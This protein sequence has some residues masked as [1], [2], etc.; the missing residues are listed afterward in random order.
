MQHPTLVISNLS[1]L[2]TTIVN[3]TCKPMST[4][5]LFKGNSCWAHFI[6][7]LRFLVPS[8]LRGSTFRKA[9]QLARSD[10]SVHL[11][12]ELGGATRNTVPGHGFLDGYISWGIFGGWPWILEPRM[13]ISFLGHRKTHE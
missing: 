3:D 4:P 6:N 8:K 10:V 7:F 13:L 1:P 11:R 9:F 12:L 2:I 5:Q